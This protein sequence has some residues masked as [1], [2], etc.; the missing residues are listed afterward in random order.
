[1]ALKNP[2]VNQP[3]VDPHS[4]LITQA[5]LRYLIALTTVLNQII[6]LEEAEE[7]PLVTSTIEGGHF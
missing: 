4:G 3:L 6:H 1:M 7:P 5:W 2:S